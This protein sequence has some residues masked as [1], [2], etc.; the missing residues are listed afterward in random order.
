M[1]S[2]NKPCARLRCSF[3][4]TALAIWVA[5]GKKLQNRLRLLLIEE[6]LVVAEVAKLHHFIGHIEAKSVTAQ[7]KRSIVRSI[8]ADGIDTRPLIMSHYDARSIS[9]ASKQLTATWQ[10]DLQ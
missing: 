4:I 8:I 9:R 6:Q 1:A 3:V 10:A 7:P 2:T 5:S